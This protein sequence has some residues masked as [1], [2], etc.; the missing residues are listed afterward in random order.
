M[1]L[2]DWVVAAYERPGVPEACLTLQDAH[3]LNTSYLL[4]AWQAG[5]TDAARLAQGAALARAWDASALH[6]IRAARR[7]LKAPHPPVDDAVREA[8]REEVKA[9]ELHAERV[10][11]ETLERLGQGPGGGPGGMAA[12]EAAAEAA[13]SPAPAPALAALAAALG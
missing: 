6:P 8:L 10:L 2:W 12:L 13:G 11:V 7:A 3:G 9:M 4:W 1:A 5:V